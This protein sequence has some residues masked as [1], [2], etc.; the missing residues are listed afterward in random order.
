[1]LKRLID[2][3]ESEGYWTLQAQ[4]LAANTASLRLH[5]AAGFREIGYRERLGHINGVWHDVI[6]LERRSRTV[7]GPGLP[8]RS[9]G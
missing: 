5:R 7:G 4:I 2:A 9:C 1:M 3:S 6:V 8:G